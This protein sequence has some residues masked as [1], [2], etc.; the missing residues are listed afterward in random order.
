MPTLESTVER[1]ALDLDLD[2]T[3][4]LIAPTVLAC[5]TAP[6]THTDAC[7]SDCSAFTF[8]GC[9]AAC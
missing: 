8:G 1:P 7:T 3:P 4:V 9:T 2:S 6:C 5:A